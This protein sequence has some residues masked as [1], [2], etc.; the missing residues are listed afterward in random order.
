MALCVQKRGSGEQG[1]VLGRHLARE[2][3]SRVCCRVEWRVQCQSGKKQLM[4]PFDFHSRAQEPCKDESC[5]HQSEGQFE[6]PY[7]HGP[8]VILS[9]T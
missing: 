6:L 1:R 3:D 4:P 7:T 8:A 2:R 9:G 5:R